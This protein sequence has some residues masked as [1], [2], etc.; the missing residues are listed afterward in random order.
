[1]ARPIE[2][3]P[4]SEAAPASRWAGFQPPKLPEADKL[5]VAVETARKLTPTQVLQVSIN[6]GIHNADGTLTAKYR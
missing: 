3:N 2:P 1:M 6:A 5:K 4:A